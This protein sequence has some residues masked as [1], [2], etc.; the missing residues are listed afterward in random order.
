FRR[1]PSDPCSISQAERTRQ[2]DESI[3]APA[4]R[5]VQSTLQVR[6]VGQLQGPGLHGQRLR[7]PRQLSKLGCVDVGIPENSDARRP[8]YDLL[9]DLQVLPAQLGKI[10]K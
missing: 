4:P 8:G 7:D 3:G 10:K 5:R 9:E 1:E 2:N 6:G